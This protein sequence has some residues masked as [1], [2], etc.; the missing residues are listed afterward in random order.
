[1]I[2]L[3][4]NR[5]MISFSFLSMLSGQTVRVCPEGKSVSTFPD[6]ALTEP[7]AF[8]DH[9]DLVAVGIGDEEKA[10]ECCAVMLEIAQRPGRQ[11]L[12]LE[13]GMLGIE[14]VDHDG[15]M[16]ISVARNVRLL[17]LEIHSEFEFEWRRR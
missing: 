12:S 3:D 15:E 17:S 6:H 8:L 13:P 4:L 10:R 1:M 2:R 7:A 5:I 11:F 9:L 14:I 16:A